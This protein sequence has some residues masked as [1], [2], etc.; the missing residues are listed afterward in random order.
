MLKYT[1]L[2]AKNEQQVCR[3]INYLVWKDCLAMNIDKSEILRIRSKWRA[4]S[5]FFLNVMVPS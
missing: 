2:L 4:G 1:A 5:A 3:V